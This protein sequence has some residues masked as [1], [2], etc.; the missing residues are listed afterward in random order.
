MSTV[1]SPSLLPGSQGL[2][3]ADTGR[4][5][6][7]SEPTGAPMLMGGG[8]HP[9]VPS[10]VTGHLSGQKVQ[11]DCAGAAA[12]ETLT[13]RTN[14]KTFRAFWGRARKSTQ[15]AEMSPIWCSLNNFIH[16]AK[17]RFSLY[18]NIFHP[19]MS[20]VRGRG[21]TSFLYM[22]FFIRSCIFVVLKSKILFWLGNEL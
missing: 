1:P 19:Q 8:V 9:G 12:H 13:P 20:I 4:R 5:L 10:L 21:V 15:T 7:V 6:Q 11:V 17:Q 16:S 18:V 14:L 3:D 22:F 2:C